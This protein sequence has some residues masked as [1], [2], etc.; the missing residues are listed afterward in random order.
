LCQESYPKLTLINNDTL[1]IFKP[2]QV[3]KIHKAFIEL[4][5]E[6]YL[7]KSLNDE[8]ELHK[9]RANLSNSEIKVLKDKI[10]LMNNISDGKTEQVETL[11]EELKL[12][13]K[14]IKR[15]KRTRT[16]YTLG[17]FIL[18]FIISNNIN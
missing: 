11:E 3:K 9:E 1:V 14:K 18:G 13:D 17:S 12:R 10:G 15:T 4:D 7:N 2:I 8:I 5:K 6:I 16:I